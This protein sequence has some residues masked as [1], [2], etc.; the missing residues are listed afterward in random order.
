MKKI[1]FLVITLISSAA[2]SLAYAGCAPGTFGIYFNNNSN[3]AVK[4]QVQ[5]FVTG[6][7]LTPVSPAVATNN[8]VTLCFAE[9][10]DEYKLMQYAPNKTSEYDISNTTL[11]NAN[12]FMTIYATDSHFHFITPK[13]R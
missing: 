5:D 10:Y 3:Q 13:N 6:N 11:V 8:G 7:D 2:L 4:V 12:Y 9:N 1:A